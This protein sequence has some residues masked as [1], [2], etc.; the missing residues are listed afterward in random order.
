MSVYSYA[1]AMIFIYCIYVVVFENRKYETSK[2][3]LLLKVIL[4]IMCPLQFYMNYRLALFISAQKAFWI[5]TV[6]II[7]L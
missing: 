6:I 3:I 1:K 4:A 5:L 7:D 2:L